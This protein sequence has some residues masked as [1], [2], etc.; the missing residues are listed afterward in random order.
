MDLRTRLGR[1]EL[2][3]PILVASGTFGYAHEAAP[4]VPPGRLG[5]II[6]K[7]ITL[8]PRRGNPPPR[9]V[10]TA[11]GMLNAIGL[12]NDGIAHFVE[13]HL[14]YLRGLGTRLIVSIAGKTAAE[15]VELARRLADQ[16][17]IDALELNLSCPNVSGGID[18]ATDPAVTGRVVADV[19]RVC[20]Y[21]LL[22]KLT[23]N[24]TH[25]VPI[26][27]AA[28]EAGAEALTLI[29]TVLATAIDWRRRRPILAN[30]LG[31]LSGPA[32]KP[33][34]L[35]IVL[36]VAEALDIAIVGVGGI[37]TVDDVMEFLV[38]GARAVQIGT[39]N[40]YDP[41]ISVRLL[42][43]LPAALHSLGAESVTEV[44]GSATRR[45]ESVG[46]GGAP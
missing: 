36:E 15:F 39:A 6:P 29:N 30:R 18:F 5:A 33:I 37:G 27:R 42:D 7:T 9:I 17:G 44:V 34:A 21:P 1:L 4:F 20:P 13:H 32:I 28:A 45:R 14:P 43:E 8:D 22:A 31:G 10:E 11:S 19:R 2:A 41:G 16:E 40:Y 12:D 35:R 25:V 46:A 24:V 38:A 26:A 3:N 23:P